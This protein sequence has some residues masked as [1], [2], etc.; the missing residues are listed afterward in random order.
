MAERHSS[1]HIPQDFERVQAQVAQ[2]RSSLRELGQ[3]LLEW[4]QRG[5]DDARNGLQ[6][7]A[8]DLGEAVH[9]TVEMAYKQGSKVAE[10]VSDT[11]EAAHK[12]GSKVV[13]GIGSQSDKSPYA[14]TLPTISAGVGVLLLLVSGVSWAAKR[15][16]R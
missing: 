11:A 16:R 10:V 9:D 7:K 1:E 3:T 8:Q 12:Q 13:E 5:V 14:A 2:L 4:G 6:A 15:L